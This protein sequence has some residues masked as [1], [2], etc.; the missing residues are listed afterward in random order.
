M[1]DG[2]KFGNSLEAL[3]RRSLIERNLET[4]S[5]NI[6]RRKLFGRLNTLIN[7]EKHEKNV[8]KATLRPENNYNEKNSVKVWF[9]SAEWKQIEEKMED[10]YE[11]AKSSKK[12]TAKEFLDYGLTTRFVLSK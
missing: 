10:I 9:A 4:I 3:T 2:H 5:E 6:K 8:A 7:Q 11:R 12:I 1:E